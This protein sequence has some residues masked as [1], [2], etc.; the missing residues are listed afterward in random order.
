[1]LGQSTRVERSTIEEV[2]ARIAYFREQKREASKAK[3]FDFNRRL[4]ELKEKADAERAAKKAQKKAEKEKAR[5][6]L[7]KEF[8][9]QEDD[10]M[11]KMMGFGGF[12]STKK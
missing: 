4:A 5:M 1:M 3:E 6:E 7:V 11:A 9:T 12:G 2:R 10:E 8:A